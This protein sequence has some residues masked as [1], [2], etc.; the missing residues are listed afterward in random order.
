M[1]E[2]ARSRG[3]CCRLR[4]S[5]KT[6]S[7]QKRAL[8]YPTHYVVTHISLRCRICRN[9][10]AYLTT[11]RHISLRCSISR[12]DAAYLATIQHILLRCSI[13]RYGAG[14]LTTVQHFSLRFS[15]SL[16]FRIS[17]YGAAYRATVQHTSQQFSISRFALTPD[18]IPPKRFATRTGFIN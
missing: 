1:N 4:R 3:S 18:S 8:G 7:K 10:T 11:M 15:I 2:N 14:Y 17:S 9:D 5:L 12:G 16:R 13:F 6:H